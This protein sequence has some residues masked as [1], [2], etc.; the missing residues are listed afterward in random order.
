MI[1]HGSNWLDA[2]QNHDSSH[3]MHGLLN[4]ENAMLRLFVIYTLHTHTHTNCLRANMYG[5]EHVLFVVVF[6]CL[7]SACVSI[8]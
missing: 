8:R 1:F 2:V 3:V 4:Y 5:L 6:I 7:L